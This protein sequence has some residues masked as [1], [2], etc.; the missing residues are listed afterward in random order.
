MYDGPLLLGSGSGGGMDDRQKRH[1]VPNRPNRPLSPPSRLVPSPEAGIIRLAHC[2]H[3][4]KACS[5]STVLAVQIISLDQL[6]VVIL[7]VRDMRQYYPPSVTRRNL[8]HFSTSPPLST[9]RAL[10]RLKTSVGRALP[11]AQADCIRVTSSTSSTLILC[12][13]AYGTV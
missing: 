7:V 11:Y 3:L 2:Y 5:Y 13:L 8:K 6:G 1:L 4:E 9:F 12:T 10:H